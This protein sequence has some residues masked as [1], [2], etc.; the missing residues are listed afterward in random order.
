M[1][2]STQGV[3]S[4]KAILDNTVKD[5][6]P[7]LSFTAIDK[8][9]T[10]LVQHTTGTLGL[11]SSSPLTSDTVFWMASC[12]KLVTAIAALQLH[13]QGKMPLDDADFVSRIAPEIKEKKVYADGINGVEQERGVTVRMLLAHTAGFG[14]CFIDPRVQLGHD[15]E[16]KF[17]DKGDILGSR[18]V[19]QPGSMWE[20]GVSFS[21]AFRSYD[22]RFVVVVV[23]IV[24]E[25][26]EGKIV[27]VCLLLL[28]CM[29]VNRS[30]SI[31]SAF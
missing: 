2:I 5:G 18:M 13:E 28:T 20:Y 24:E 19:N 23:I 14:Y 29:C 8:S 9:G 16:G 10:T 15:F 21:N 4:V 25:G 30:I 31:G 7:G 6:F 11:N 17:G 22:I 27:R 12:T 26:V 3:E 1:P